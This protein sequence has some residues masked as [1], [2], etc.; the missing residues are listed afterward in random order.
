MSSEGLNFDKK[1]NMPLRPVFDILYICASKYEGEWAS[2]PHTHHFTELFYV[3]SGQG[4]FWVEDRRIPVQKND[5]VIVNP[6]IEHTEKSKNSQPLEY[7]V[8]GVDGLI[9]ELGDQNYAFCTYS[10]E[11]KHHLN[12]P[13]IIMQELTLKHSGYEA[14]C[15]NILEVL[16]IFISRNEQ[17]GFLAANDS[18]IT[19]ECAAAKRFLD[20]NYH[21][22]ITLDTLAQSAHM[23]KFHLSHTFTRCLGVSPIQYL[24]NRR[25][26]VARDLLTQTDQPIAQIAVST[27]FTSQSYF[28]QIFRRFTGMSP[29]QYR[30]EKR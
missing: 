18:Q 29:K 19:R 11:E 12:V 17:F 15:R 13:Q 8:F 23:N 5:M 21:Q 26:Q 9:F 7:I 6:H 24:I 1:S 16:I 10:P 2:S 25:L 28:S 4:E 22:S 20:S 27:G 14:V 3:V 30:K